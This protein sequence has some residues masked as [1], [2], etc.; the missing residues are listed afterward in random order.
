MAQAHNGYIIQH[1][2]SQ[3]A[4]HGP[5]SQRIYNTTYSKRRKNNPFIQYRLEYD[6]RWN[7][8]IFATSRL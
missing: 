1:I 8:L 5:S 4:L 2:H 7:I 6:V 3:G